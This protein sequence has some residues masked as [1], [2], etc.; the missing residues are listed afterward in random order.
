M[1]S[2]ESD[3][4]FFFSLPKQAPHFLELKLHLF[5]QI[6]QIFVILPEIYSIFEQPKHQWKYQSSYGSSFHHVLKHRNIKDIEF[7]YSR[8]QDSSQ[9]DY[10]GRS[11]TIPRPLPAHR[12][13]SIID[14]RSP[15]IAAH[16]PNH[17]LLLLSPVSGSQK[18]SSQQ[19]GE[20]AQE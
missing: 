14:D 3:F 10:L 1:D 13:H 5:Q 20:K 9:E 16:T 11:P 7:H 4:C 2:P 12:L 8:C 18:I 6:S 19:G 17:H 15:A